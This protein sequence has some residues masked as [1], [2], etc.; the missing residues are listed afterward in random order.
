MREFRCGEYTSEGR[1]TDSTM[2][3]FVLRQQLEKDDKKEGEGCNDELMMSDQDYRE[4][5][6]HAVRIWSDK[7]KNTNDDKGQDDNNE[8]E[9][10]M[11][12]SSNSSNSDTDDTDDQMDWNKPTTEKESIGTAIINDHHGDS[13]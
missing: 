2:T 9:T 8:Q 10:T 12:G 1:T 11:T 13:E 4:T 3:D 5:K 6:N 7:G